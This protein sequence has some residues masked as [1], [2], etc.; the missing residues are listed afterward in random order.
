MADFAQFFY[1]FL[2]VKA[3]LLQGREEQFNDE[4]E[5]ECTSK[6]ISVMVSRQSVSTMWLN[7]AIT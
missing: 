6:A 2:S 7:N 1:I 5:M 4:L 3:S